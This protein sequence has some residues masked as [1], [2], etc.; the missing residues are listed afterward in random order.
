MRLFLWIVMCA[1]PLLGRDARSLWLDVPFVAQPENACG[2]ACIAMVMSYWSAKDGTPPP[3][4]P[5][6]GELYARLRG[7]G[8]KGI[9]AVK[10]QRYLE[11]QGFRAIAFAGDWGMLRDHLSKGRPL[12][13]ALGAKSSA[14]LAHY[15]V[16]VGLDEGRDRVLLNDPA[17]RKLSEEPRA[18]FERR[19]ALSGRWT[20]LAV[21]G[22]AR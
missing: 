14:A 11:E 8:R 21:P 16:V 15:V 17:R 12:I 19:W 5:D 2:A 3:A 20:L 9:P 18:D 22:N 10:L 6:P 1:A 4:A 7:N 13:A